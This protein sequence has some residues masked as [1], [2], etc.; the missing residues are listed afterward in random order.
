MDSMLDNSL[1]ST[2]KQIQLIYFLNVVVRCTNLHRA[3]ISL[4][5]ID[6]SRS[7]NVVYQSDMYVD[8]IDSYE[9]Q[10]EIFLASIYAYV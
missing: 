8:D 1:F 10:I 3:Q 4:S 7:V 9:H 5:Q 2:E 6:Y